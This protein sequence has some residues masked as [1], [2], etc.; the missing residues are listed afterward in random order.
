MKMD[1]LS[2]AYDEAVL[3]LIKNWS[4]EGDPSFGAIWSVPLYHPIIPHD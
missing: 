1:D 2:E 3:S 4:E